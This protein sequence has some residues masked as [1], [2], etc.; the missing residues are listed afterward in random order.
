MQIY[1]F[2]RQRLHNMGFDETTVNITPLV[3]S[4]DAGEN[5]RLDL[6]GDYLFMYDVI[7]YE[8]KFKVESDISVAFEDDF[9]I[10]QKIPSGILEL[11][12]NVFIETEANTAD[13]ND[14]SNKF[15]FYVAS[16]ANLLNNN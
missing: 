2:I 11:H 1:D 12:G 15:M 14:N 5:M 3:V 7:N 16:P 13:T 10:D 8:G 6:S 9:I 4:M